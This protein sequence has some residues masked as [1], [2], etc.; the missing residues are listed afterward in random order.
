[1]VR[2]VFPI[3]EKGMVIGVVLQRGIKVERDEN[4][5]GGSGREGNTEKGNGERG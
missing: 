3:R 1:M 5:R 4:P 2:E